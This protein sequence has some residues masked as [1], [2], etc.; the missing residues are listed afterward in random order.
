MCRGGH[1]D[2]DCKLVCEWEGCWRG[3][4]NS[5]GWVRTPKKNRVKRSFSPL[6]SSGLE[7]EGAGTAAS[8]SLS[9]SFSRP[10]NDLPPSGIG[11]NDLPM[12]EKLLRCNRCEEPE[13]GD[14]LRK[15]SGGESGEKRDTSPCGSTLGMGGWMN[16]G[17]LNFERCR[18]DEETG[19]FEYDMVVV[20]VRELKDTLA[21]ND[22]GYLILSRCPIV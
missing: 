16:R 18:C 19:L 3:I 11:E 14:G 8:T 7:D 20:A 21:N 22:Q 12:G 6:P 13:W 10:R 2:N 15:G 1:S 17:S 5:L 9:L 4:I